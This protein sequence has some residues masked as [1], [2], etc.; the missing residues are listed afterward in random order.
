[1][2]FAGSCRHQGC[3]AVAAYRACNVLLWVSRYDYVRARIPS[4]TL[5]TPAWYD[6]PLLRTLLLDHKY[7]YVFKMDGAHAPRRL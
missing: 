4:D 1:M 6:V 7:G 5:R 3:S 2:P